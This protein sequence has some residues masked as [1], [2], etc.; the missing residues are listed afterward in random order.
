MIQRNWF[1]FALFMN[2]VG[3]YFKVMDF[4]EI[5]VVGYSVF[6]LLLLLGVFLT[7]KQ[8]FFSRI[9][10][11]VLLL[12]LILHGLISLTLPIGIVFALTG[13]Y[14]LALKVFITFYLPSIMLVWVNLYGLY[15]LEKERK[16]ATTLP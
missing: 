3:S 12:F 16:K 10:Q 8:S 2:I 11:V 1:W 9:Q 4:S 5:D 15:I 14:W 7:R 13:S 6:R